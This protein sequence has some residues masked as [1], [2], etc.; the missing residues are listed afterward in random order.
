VLGTPPLH[1]IIEVCPLQITE[2]FAIAISFGSTDTLNC[3]APIHPAA[4][5]IFKV[6]IPDAARF[7]A[8]LLIV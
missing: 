2:G 5:F 8:F 1:R 4:A 3:A 6:T 7:V